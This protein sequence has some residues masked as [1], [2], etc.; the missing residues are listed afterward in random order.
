MEYINKLSLQIDKKQ[1]LQDVEY[2]LGLTPLWPNQQISLTSV[3]GNDDWDCSIGK[4]AD[5]QH[6]ESDFTVVNNSI[7]DRYIGELIQ[8]L[9]PNYCRW[10]I[11]NKARR[12]C[13]SVHHDGTE[14]L[15][16]LHIPVITNDQNFLMFYTDKPVASDTGTD[17]S[18]KHYNLEP[19]YAYLMRTNYLHSA[20][21]F[22]NED[23]IHLVATQC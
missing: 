13:Y 10:R 17:I 5:L 3:T 22:S 21:N 20:V 15:L 19:G 23:R 14:H 16:R 9:A 1:L 6:K 2:I 7:K 4:I 18:I 12:T 8:S 11:M